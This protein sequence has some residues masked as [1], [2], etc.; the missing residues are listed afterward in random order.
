[1]RCCSLPF[2]VKTFNGI[3]IPALKFCKDP[4]NIR[5][6]VNSYHESCNPSKLIKVDKLGSAE[7]IVA[8]PI[9]LSYVVDYDAL[10]NFQ[11]KSL[12]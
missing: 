7:H 8:S 12:Y 10:F 3:I 9:V 1:M 2:P 5:L 4:F 6:L 11:H